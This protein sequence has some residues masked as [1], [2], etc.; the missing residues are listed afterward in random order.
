MALF[1]QTARLLCYTL[2]VEAWKFGGVE[3]WPSR[4]TPG[5]PQA[6]FDRAL[7]R[8]PKGSGVKP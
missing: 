7:A 1:Y 2:R 5:A 6:D 8:N 3:A 4:L